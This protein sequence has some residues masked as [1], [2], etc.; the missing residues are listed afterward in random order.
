MGL[1]DSIGVAW[2]LCVAVE[3]V[4]R[5]REI[6]WMFLCLELGWRKWVK[7]GTYIDGSSFLAAGAV[8]ATFQK[9]S[10]KSWLPAPQRAAKT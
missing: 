4:A 2:S 8:H 1:C 3:G 6:V 10:Q 7:L 9:Q 5:A